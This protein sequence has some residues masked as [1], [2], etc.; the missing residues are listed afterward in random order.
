MT[1][2]EMIQTMCG[3]LGSGGLHAMLAGEANNRF[4]IRAAAHALM[5]DR[6]HFD[7]FWTRAEDQ[8][9]AELTQEGY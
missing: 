6:R 9:R 7:G 1:R 4:D 8:Q 5:H 3:G 2:R